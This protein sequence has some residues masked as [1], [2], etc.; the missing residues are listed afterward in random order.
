MFK[1]TM[2][3]KQTQILIGSLIIIAILI[4]ATVLTHNMLT[5]PYPGHNDFMSRWEGV[6]SYWI[7]GLNPY[8]EQASLNIQT[9]IYGRASLPN[10]DPG[11][12]AYPFYTTFLML[13][14][15]FTDYAWASAIWMVVLAA[16]L[17][18][19][20]IINLSILRWKPAPI[21]LGVLLLWV[22]IDYYAMRGLLLGQPGILVAFL[23]FLA[24]WAF[25]KKRDALGGFA[26]ALST[27]KP[28]MGF[29]IV[30][31]LLLVA[32]SQRRWRYLAST[33]L[34]FGGL[35]LASFLL[36][37]TWL[38][39]WL[40][41]IGNYS[42]YTALG[43]PVWIITQHYLNL[44]NVGEFIAVIPL[45]FVML[46]AWF[47]VIVRQKF[48]RFLWAAIL[49][50]TIT[51]LIAPRTATPHYVVFT[52]PILFYLH[53]IVKGRQTLIALLIPIAMVVLTWIH[54][55]TTVTG[56]FE[57]PTLYLP[58]PFTILALLLITR[59]KWWKT[60]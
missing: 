23:E 53:E 18:G 48:D 42:S 45:V 17:I 22:L 39:D 55:I 25:L 29:L 30:P 58:L 44:G 41:Q 59:K 13:P 10:E 2:T 5:A 36:Q 51:H 19:A 20:L 50:L 52:L 31:F 6:R 14:L 12:F 11:Y 38:S 34:T 7:D 37:P 4:G 16:S 43:S 15:V 57:H 26:L 24:I 28:Q 60:V 9:R 1:P 40:G 46:W 3:H 33:T 49:T 47:Q 27:L 21:M 56:E 32:L 8:G 35:M 54:F